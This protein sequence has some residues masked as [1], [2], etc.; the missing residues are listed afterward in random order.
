MSKHKG[1]VPSWPL[2]FGSMKKARTYLEKALEIN[3]Q[4]LDINFFYADYLADT[5][6][7]QQALTYAQ[8]ALEAPKLEN[9]PL[10]DAGRRAQARRLLKDLQS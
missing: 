7:R 2:G 6:D 4:G 8:R 3:P 5:G 9:R 1:K 10:A